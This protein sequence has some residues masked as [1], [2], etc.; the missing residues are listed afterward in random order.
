MEPE[1][2]FNTYIESKIKNSLYS[3]TSN[4]FSVNILDL[5]SKVKQFENEDK[6]ADKLFRNIFIGIFLSIIGITLI[7][8]YSVTFSGNIVNSDS[9]FVKSFYEL[10]ANLNLRQ[11]L[12][13]QSDFNIILI[14]PLALV[15]LVIFNYL[16]TRYIKRNL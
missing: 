10:Y 9:F 14:I 7:V 8:I 4:S 2:L 5:L 3:K 11:V 6:K 13:S 12:G 1:K 16:D 15:L